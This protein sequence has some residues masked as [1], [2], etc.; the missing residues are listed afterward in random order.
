MRAIGMTGHGIS[1]ARLAPRPSRARSGHGR[2]PGVGYDALGRHVPLMGFTSFLEGF[3]S[4]FRGLH[5][6]LRGLHKPLRG[7]S[8]AS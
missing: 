4:L 2:N 3:T 6:P 5:K 7:A 8:F 1:G